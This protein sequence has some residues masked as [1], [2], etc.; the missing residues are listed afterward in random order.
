MTCLGLILEGDCVILWLF[1]FISPE[2]YSP[3][4]KPYLQ[5]IRLPA[6]L[7]SMTNSITGFCIAY[8][9]PEIQVFSPLFSICG[10]SI[11]LYAS[12]MILNDCFDFKEDQQKQ[13]PKP[14]VQG[15][16]SVL[17]AFIWGYLFQII[18]LFWAYLIS[19]HTG[20]IAS[21]IALFVNAYDIGMKHFRFLG[22]ATMAACRFMNVLLG[23]SLFWQGLSPEKWIFPAFLFGY[24]FCLTR[25][26]QMEE[27]KEN[28]GRFAVNASGLLLLPV[29]A[30]CS[31]PNPMWAV[32]FVGLLL[33][34]LSRAILKAWK[35]YDTPHLVV[36]VKTTVLGVVLL[37]AIILAGHQ[38]LFPALF[39][40]GILLVSSRVARF[41]ST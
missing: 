2:K 26:S 28:K 8:P 18:A 4:I 35:H 38:H 32:P 19:L 7:T 3:M 37:D 27:L 30:A 36:V 9:L 17:Y 16:I 34:K 39:C 13:K 6:V 40:F 21:I 15:E 5:L 10:V 24:V 31:C 41:I 22:G 23:M 20:I 33:Y 1:A 14:L 11:L 29:L 25:I 12:G